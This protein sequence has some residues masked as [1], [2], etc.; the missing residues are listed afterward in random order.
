MPGVLTEECNTFILSAAEVAG[1]V[2]SAITAAPGCRTGPPERSGLAKSPRGRPTPYLPGGRA[3]RSPGRRNDL[4]DH[5]VA[6][7]GDGGAAIIGAP[8]AYPGVVRQ[9][10][11]PRRR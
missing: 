4:R 8:D 11:G 5:A 7:D 6:R 9:S 10:P 1:P 2:A 3:H